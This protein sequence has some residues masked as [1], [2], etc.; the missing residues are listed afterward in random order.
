V[1]RRGPRA[2]MPRW[3]LTECRRKRARLRA[4][5]EDVSDNGPQRRPPVSKPLTTGV[6]SP[7]TES[8][9]PGSCSDGTRS[10]GVP[11]PVAGLLVHARGLRARAELVAGEHLHNQRGE[12]GFV[13]RREPHQT[14]IQNALAEPPR[15]SRDPAAGASAGTVCRQ[16]NR[17][18][19]SRA[20]VTARSRRPRSIS[21][22]LG[23]SRVRRVARRAGDEIVVIS[24]R[25][26]D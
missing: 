19:A 25:G 22:S 12:H 24:S 21:A 23:G 26:G 20:E 18:S 5:C 11:L 4:S 2:L 14:R 15:A 8:D 9:R 6:R 16:R 3:P 1:G 7:T 10:R 13:Q 17:T